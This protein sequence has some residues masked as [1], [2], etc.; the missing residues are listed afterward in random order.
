M[1]LG[2][3]TFIASVWWN[4]VAGDWRAMNQECL[5]CGFTDPRNAARWALG[6]P[7]EAK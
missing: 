6:L 1:R 7:H 3:L 5:R 4:P 2:P